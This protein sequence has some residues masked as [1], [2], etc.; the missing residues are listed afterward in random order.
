MARA[1]AT[2]DVLA[3]EEL[4]VVL[5]HFG[6]GVLESVTEFPK[7]SRK[8]PK[9][10]VAAE[11]GKFLLKRRAKGRDDPFKVAFC[12]AI[13]L[14]LAAK[15]FPLPSLIG[16]KA[17]NNS[18]L[19]WRGHV[20]EL[21]EFIQG[22]P[23]PQTSDSTRDSGRVLAVFHGLLEGFRSEWQPGGGS[24]HNSQYVDQA[25]KQIPEKV[26][27]GNGDVEGTLGYLFE[28][29]QTCAA[30]VEKGGIAT[31]PN[32]VVHGDWHPGNMLFRD[33]A[34][35]AVIDYDSA[36]IL[37]RAID[38]ANGAL[39]FSII[40]EEEDVSFWPAHLDENRYRAFLAGYDSVM[41]VSKAEMR[42][43]PWL[44]IEALI[45]E[46]VIPIAATGMF[47]RTEGMKF[48]EMVKR[49]VAWLKEN[50]A[51]LGAEIPTPV[52]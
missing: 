40:G 5:S 30:E 42:M 48:L 44:M 7:G 26:A 27:R 1:G 11:Q 13:Q 18:M 14:H 6:I 45:A 39:Q 2:R 19:Q 50:S 16:T 33:D 43:L 47:G 35:V 20:Y 36:R 3:A 51:K 24:Y 41:L 29:Y 23:Y 37:P 25:V 49:K 12:H 38:V 17:D 46:A 9:M 32:Q 21:F 31:W 28:M 22:Q 10:L 52:S 4:A 8:A 34:V 15:G